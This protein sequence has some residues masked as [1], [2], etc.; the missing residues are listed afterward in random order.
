MKK[1]SQLTV[2]AI[3]NTEKPTGLSLGF[4][5]PYTIAAHA[6]DVTSA[7]PQNAHAVAP[8]RSSLEQE[9]KKQSQFS[10]YAIENTEKPTAHQSTSCIAATSGHAMRAPNRPARVSAADQASAPPV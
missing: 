9:M 8:P 4:G 2:Y 7:S 6:V 1:Q 5:R 10:S 3:E